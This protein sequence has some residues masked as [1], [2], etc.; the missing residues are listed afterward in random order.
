MSFPTFTF[1]CTASRCLG[2]KQESFKRQILSEHGSIGP[3]QESFKRHKKADRR[4]HNTDK[5]TKSVR[6]YNEANEIYYRI[7]SDEDLK[8]AWLSEEEESASRRAVY[9]SIQAYRQEA[10]Q[11]SK[12]L[13]PDVSMRGLEHH[14][15]ALY[16]EQKL[17]QGKKIRQSIL[18][19][20]N[21][22][23]AV[24]KLSD[25]LSADDVKYAVE[26]AAL[27]AGIAMCLY[28]TADR[29]DQRGDTCCPSESFRSMTLSST[30]ANGLVGK[31][32]LFS[33]RRQTSRKALPS[34]HQQHQQDHEGNTHA[35]MADMLD[36]A[37]KKEIGEWWTRA[38]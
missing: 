5:P 23:A 15:S 1:N 38:N 26:L 35:K 32:C 28:Y 6:F 10:E 34:K 27:D 24:A 25:E 20:Q 8:N 4:T 17:L 12:E 9:L 11:G 37:L 7:L 33:L 19:A 14:A 30:S 16:T 36:Q 13:S 18:L 29:D 31:Y 21:D 3:K 22:A 2:P